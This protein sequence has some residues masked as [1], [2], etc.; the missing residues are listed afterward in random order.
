MK[1]I[2]LEISKLEKSLLNLE[3]TQFISMDKNIYAICETYL[4]DACIK[5]FELTFD[6]L[7]KTLR[8]FF[9]YKGIELHYPKDVLKEGYL[10]D[11]LEDELLWLRM[12]Q[13]YN[14][15]AYSYDD[16]LASDLFKRIQL[17]IPL[18]RNAFNKLLKSVKE[19]ECDA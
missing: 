10:T 19:I 14:I 8:V 7:W 13:D 18:I 12:L 17:Y 4:M 2:R 1:K 11:Y 5:R 15:S 9:Y 16:T 6:L 3:S